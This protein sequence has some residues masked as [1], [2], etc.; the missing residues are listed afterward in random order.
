M[1]S[2]FPPST[3]VLFFSLLSFP[4]S[5]KD[6]QQSRVRTIRSNNFPLREENTY[7]RF[8]RDPSLAKSVRARKQNAFIGARDRKSSG[9]WLEFHI[10]ASAPSAGITL[11]VTNLLVKRAVLV[12]KREPRMKN[13]G[14]ESDRIVTTSHSY[15][16]F[17]RGNTRIPF[18]KKNSF[19]PFHVARAY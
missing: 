16:I 13:N 15:G 17:L 4:P 6:I 5:I 2:T 11:S 3:P 12:V 7:P 9:N 8:S 1:K 19:Y 10:F 14:S 18:R